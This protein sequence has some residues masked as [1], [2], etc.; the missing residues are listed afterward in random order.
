MFERLNSCPVV[1]S[2]HLEGS[3]S[4]ERRIYLTRLANQGIPQ[5]PCPIWKN[6]RDIMAFPRFFVNENL[7]KRCCEKISTKVNTE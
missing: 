3:L 4:F 1:L 6:N 5:E 2:R 7:K